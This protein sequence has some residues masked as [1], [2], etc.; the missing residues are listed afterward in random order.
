MAFVRLTRRSL[1]GFKTPNLA[2]IKSPKLFSLGA[3]TCGREN[4]P[5]LCSRRQNLS[6][7]RRAAQKEMRAHFCVNRCEEIAQLSAVRLIAP[8][9]AAVKLSR[10]KCMADSAVPLYAAAPTPTPPS[11]YACN[12]QQRSRFESL[13][14]M[15]CG[16]VSRRPI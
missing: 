7:I 15:T 5:R 10:A 8:C 3:I 12:R 13:L 16:S 14:R 2:L 9:A 1:S 4:H 6:E 11:D